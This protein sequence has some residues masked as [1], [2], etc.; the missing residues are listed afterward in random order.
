[1]PSMPMP[2]SFPVL[3]PPV[4]LDLDAVRIVSPPADEIVLPSDDESRARHHASPGYQPKQQQQRENGR[5]RHVAS[6]G[7]PRSAAAPSTPPVGGRPVTPPQQLRS[8]SNSTPIESIAEEGDHQ[9]NQRQRHSPRSPQPASSLPQWASLTPPPLSITPRPQQQQ[10]QPR[11]SPSSSFSSSTSKASKASDDD[12]F[13]DK[14]VASGSNNISAPI[15]TNPPPVLLQPAVYDPTRTRAATQQQTGGG[16]GSAAPMTTAIANEISSVQRNLELEAA[17]QRMA[18][19]VAARKTALRK[20]R[21]AV[22]GRLRLRDEFRGAVPFGSSSDVGARTDREREREREKTLKEGFGSGGVGMGMR[23]REG[24]LGAFGGSGSGGG[25]NDSAVDIVLP[26]HIPAMAA[27][28][29]A[30][31]HG[32]LGK[33]S[34]YRSVDST[35]ALVPLIFA[36]S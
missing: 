24:L 27:G 36:R 11:H 4:K 5:L 29:V 20:A 28:C 22:L 6:H 13:V 10:R 19:D 14:P 23:I 30:G 17:H 32:L 26:D 35:T 31:H 25:R 12:P 1:M 3:L 34:A 33:S 8:R 18:E 15:L 21:E 2:G 7:S 16:S 9:E